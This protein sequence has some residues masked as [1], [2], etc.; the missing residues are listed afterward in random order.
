LNV[1]RRIDHFIG[2]QASFEQIMHINEQFSKKN[3]KKRIEQ[4]EAIPA[5]QIKANTAAFELIKKPGDNCYRV[6][7]KA[8]GF[9]T[10]HISSNKDGQWRQVFTKDQQQ[11]LM[12]ETADWLEKYGFSL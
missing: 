10:G 8:T 11:R 5:E 12:A 7:D 2:T 3:V 1:I 6:F 4:F 9:Q